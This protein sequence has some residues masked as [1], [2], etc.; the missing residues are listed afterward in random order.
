MTNTVV[1][2]GLSNLTTIP[3][4]FPKMGCLPTADVAVD[5]MFTS[6]PITE[7]LGAL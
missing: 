7:L 5:S 2:P 1:I 4:C 6:P 3:V